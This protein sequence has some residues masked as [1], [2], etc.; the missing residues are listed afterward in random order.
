MRRS[1][2]SIALRLC[3]VQRNRY[4]SLAEVA[5]APKRGGLFVMSF[6]LDTRGDHQIRQN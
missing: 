4:H 5:G 6:D 1:G 3:A 2:A